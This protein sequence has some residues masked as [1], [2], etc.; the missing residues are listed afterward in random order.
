MRLS[1]IFGWCRV[2]REVFRL[3]LT[4]RGPTSN[5]RHQYIKINAQSRQA[6]IRHAQ[7]RVEHPNV[8]RWQLVDSM[9]M[10]LAWG[11][12]GGLRETEVTDA[13]VQEPLPSVSRLP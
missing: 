8:L 3:R 9:G 7:E 10:Q 13:A 5:R 1:R 11:L 4:V 12:R 2:P 6:A